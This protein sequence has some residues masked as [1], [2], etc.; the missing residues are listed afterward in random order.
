MRKVS[1][2]ETIW[3][4]MTLRD[5]ALI[6]RVLFSF[7][8][9]T[10]TSHSATKRRAGVNRKP[11]LTGTA[12]WA[13]AAQPPP[14][15]A[16]N[17]TAAPRRWGSGSPERKPVSH[18]VCSEWRGTVRGVEEKCNTRRHLEDGHIL[19]LCLHEPSSYITQARGWRGQFSFG[20]CVVIV[21]L[22]VFTSFCFKE[23]LVD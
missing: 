14:P 6:M 4:D 22:L 17:W 21:L 5:D 10:V 13:T 23:H 20:V 1:G 15:V 18:A 7:C 16:A 8:L 2:P 12:R 3:E 11:P 19:F 9:L